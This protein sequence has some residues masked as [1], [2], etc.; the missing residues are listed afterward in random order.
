MI[1]GTFLVIALLY[2]AQG[3][4]RNWN[5]YR[6]RETEFDALPEHLNTQAEIDAA[7]PD[8]SQFANRKGL[9][10]VYGR[11]LKRFNKLT[12][13][14]SVF[15]PRSKFW[16][17]RWS[18]PP[19]EIFKVGGKGPWRYETIAGIPIVE[20]T[21]AHFGVVPLHHIL[22]RCQ[23]YKRWHLAVQWPLM[24]TFHVYW[25]EKDVP[26]EGQPWVNEF[27]IK[28]LLFAYGPIHWDTDIIYWLLSFYLGGQWK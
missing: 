19:R 14:W 3:T 26:V 16:W 4:Y 11:L 13:P 18:F 28:Q 24:V 25:H 22:S 7:F 21:P 5:V 20:E 1:L 12:K 6:G 10:G 9:V 15:G 23:Y 2:V 8:D 27:S 17:A